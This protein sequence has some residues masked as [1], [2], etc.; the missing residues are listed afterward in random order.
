MES[1]ALLLSTQHSVGGLSPETDKSS[2]PPH[3]LFIYGN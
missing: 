3:I 2:S 1:D